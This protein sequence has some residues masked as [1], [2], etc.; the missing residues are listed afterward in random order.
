MLHL[1]VCIKG[2]LAFYDSFP[3]LGLDELTCQVAFTQWF[4][5]VLAR[6]DQGL[7]PCQGPL[8]EEVELRTFTFICPLCVLPWFHLSSGVLVVTSQKLQKC[9]FIL[10]E[11][12]PFKL[13]FCGVACFGSW[14]SHIFICLNFSRCILWPKIAM[15]CSQNTQIRLRSDITLK[16]LGCLWASGIPENIQVGS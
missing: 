4:F 11:K 16:F 5:L 9:E 3:Q 10:S 2:T 14:L 6:H 15:H 1:G 8:H 12:P 13:M 7:S